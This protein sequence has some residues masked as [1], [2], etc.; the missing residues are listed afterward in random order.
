MKK[1]TLIILNYNEIEGLKELW[2]KIPVKEF[3]EVF[4]IDPGSTDGS[5]EFLKK[6]G[7]RVIKQEIR[8]RGEAFRIAAREARNENIV[9]FGPDGNEDPND[10]IKL[11]EC[12][13]EGYDMAVASRF[14][15]GSRSD[16]AKE[17][18]R[19]RSF[20]NIFFTKVA[21]ILWGGELTD[22]INGFRAVRKTKFKE[23]N[24]DAPGFGIEYQMS[25]RALK[26][27][28]KIKEIPTQ[29]RER[30]GGR[31]TAGS[32]KVGLLFIRLI[33]KEILIGSNFR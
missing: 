26:L 10:I 12:L 1:A 31:S 15:K 11:I 23:L 18:I 6:R 25:V 16:D 30:I 20:G 13:E 22:S 7:V 27:G 17:L 19:H 32:F 14:M 9:F 4:A 24:P 33:L 21:D 3:D 8:G 2:G 28:L 29:E 5:L